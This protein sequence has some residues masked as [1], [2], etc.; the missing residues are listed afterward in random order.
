MAEVFEFPWWLKLANPAMMALNRI[1]FAPGPVRTL[2]I[3]G[4]QT[5]ALRSTP[6]SPFTVGGQRYVSG[7]GD[8]QW[9]RNARAAGWGILRYGRTTERIALIELA[10][11]E[12]EAILREIPRQLPQGVRFYRDTLGISGDPDSFAAAA[13]HC[14]VFRIEPM[15]RGMEC[16][17]LSQPA[18]TDYGIDFH[19]VLGLDA[20]GV[21]RWN[22]IGALLTLLS[23]GTLLA[24]GRRGGRWLLAGGLFWLFHPL[25]ML[26]SSRYGKLQQRDLI[27]DEVGLRGDEQ[28]LDVGTGHGLMAI[29]AA[30]CLTSGRAIG[31]DIW[32]E[33]DQSDNSLASAMRNVQA[34]GVQGRCVIQD[35]DAREIPFPDEGFDVVL[36]NFALHNIPGTDGKRRACEEI[37]RVLKPGGRVFDYDIVFTTGFFVRAF[38]NAGLDAEQHPP[39]WW[40]Y[41]PGRLITAQKRSTT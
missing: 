14:R 39:S 13:P 19:Q 40:T 8:T 29:G 17:G 10:A 4:R 41:P 24:R 36:A 35:G 18:A 33:R 9:V 16:A 15:P 23:G 7:V 12:R 3:P 26:F 1:G 2:S 28:V 32:Q 37:A 21:I 30:K 25:A 22:A 5:G 31:I 6:V 27:L 34:E 38:Q 20:P 11:G